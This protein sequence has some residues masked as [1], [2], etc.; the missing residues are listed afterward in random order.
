MSASEKLDDMIN[1]K[2][3]YPLTFCF[4]SVKILWLCATNPFQ[5]SY[6]SFQANQN[7]ETL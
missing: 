7:T 2:K 1:L 3:F 4:A 5:N 6:M